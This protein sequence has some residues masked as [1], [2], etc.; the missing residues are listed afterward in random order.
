MEWNEDDDL[1][2]TAIFLPPHSQPKALLL[3]DLALWVFLSLSSPH[4]QFEI[5][6]PKQND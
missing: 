4:L 3:L 5:L 1:M 6:K 2:I